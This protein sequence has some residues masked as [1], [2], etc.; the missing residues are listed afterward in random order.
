MRA[1]WPRGGLW[2]HSDFLKLW[3]TETVSQLG[4]QVSG[5]ALPFVA[6]V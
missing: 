4:S 1:I 3:S 2:R 6:I 5:L